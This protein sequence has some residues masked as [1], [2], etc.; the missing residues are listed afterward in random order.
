MSLICEAQPLCVR[1]LRQDRTQAISKIIF[2]DYKKDSLLL[3]K[4]IIRYCLI[5]TI[6]QIYP[7]LRPL[8]DHICFFSLMFFCTIM[9]TIAMRALIMRHA[10]Q[11]KNTL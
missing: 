5:C 2:S 6:L 10:V 9:V 3:R 7:I 4:F 1:I 11:G 8:N